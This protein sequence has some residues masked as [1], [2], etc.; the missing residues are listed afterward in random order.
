MGR[1]TPSTDSSK[2]VQPSLRAFKSLRTIERKTTSG[3]GAAGG[4]IPSVPSNRSPTTQNSEPPSR[5]KTGKVGSLQTQSP[6]SPTHLPPTPIQVDSGGGDKQNSALVGQSA[7]QKRARPKTQNGR[8]ALQCPT[9][10]LSLLLNSSPLPLSHRLF[11]FTSVPA[12]LADRK[13]QKEPVP[14]TTKP[15]SSRDSFN[16]GPSPFALRWNSVKT[17][18]GPPDK[19]GVG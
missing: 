13:Q 14:A 9:F 2:G 1:L 12:H 6:P 4:P 10:L 15:S 11:V 17:A 3:G 16:P 18:F 5:R 19:F 8:G 7:F